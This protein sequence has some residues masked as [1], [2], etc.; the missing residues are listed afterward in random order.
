MEGRTATVQTG[1]LFPFSRADSLDMAMTA[2]VAI[3]GQPLDVQQ[4]VVHVEEQPMGGPISGIP[5]TWRWV[6]ERE[7][8]VDRVISRSREFSDLQWDVEGV[9]VDGF[10]REEVKVHI[11]NGNGSY[12]RTDYGRP[13]KRIPCDISY[14]VLVYDYR[15]TDGRAQLVGVLAKQVGDGDTFTQDVTRF[16]TDL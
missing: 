6:S 9:T 10:T 8:I 16:F 4:A 12:I 5:G 2:T 7:D 11:F 15:L 1:L 3:A 14:D 13:N